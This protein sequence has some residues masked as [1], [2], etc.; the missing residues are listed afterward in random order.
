M[1]P[2]NVTKSLYLELG[3][4][5][6]VEVVLQETLE[7]QALLVIAYPHSTLQEWTI[8]KLYWGLRVLFEERPYPVAQLFY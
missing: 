8:P 1:R 4:P 5:L 6:G 2:L 3:N 7:G